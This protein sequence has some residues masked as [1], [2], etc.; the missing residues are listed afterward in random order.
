MESKVH[1]GV[2]LKGYDDYMVWMNTT[3][4]IGIDDGTL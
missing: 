4:R 1:K 2:M 3:F